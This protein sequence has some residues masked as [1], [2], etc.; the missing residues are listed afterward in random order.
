MAGAGDIGSPNG[1]PVDEWGVRVDGCQPVGS[2]VERGGATVA[3][4]V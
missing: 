4:I 2:T 3:T 1:L